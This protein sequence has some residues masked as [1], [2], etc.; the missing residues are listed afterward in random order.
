M[1]EKEKKNRTRSYIHSH[2]KQRKNGTYIKHQ[3]TGRKIKVITKK[4]NHYK[5]VYLMEKNLHTFYSNG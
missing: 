4:E 3:Q 2:E 1:S 5:N